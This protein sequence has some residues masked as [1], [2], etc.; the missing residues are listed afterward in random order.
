METETKKT[1]QVPEVRD[2][3]D[4]YQVLR[5]IEKKLDAVMKEVERIGE[6]HKPVI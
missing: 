2:R 6:L 5:R 1:R 3:E 4:Y